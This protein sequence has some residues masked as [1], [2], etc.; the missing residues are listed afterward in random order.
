VPLCGKRAEFLP[1]ADIVR[2]A[3]E[4][5]SN[6]EVGTVDWVTFV[7]S[8]ETLLHLGLGRMLR[9]VKAITELPV[10][11]ITNG[12]LLWD[13]EVREELMPADAVLPS[14]DAGTPKLFRRINRPHPGLSFHQHLSGL[15]VFNKEYQGQLLL[16]VVL[17]RGVNDTETALS[18]LAAAVERIDPHG[19]HLSRPDRP[20]AE[21]WVTSPDEGGYMSAVAVLG[22]ATQVLHPAER[23]LVLE[24]PDG[25]L[26]TLLAVLTRHPLSEAQLKRALA[27]WS[28]ADVSRFL[29][30]LEGSP[31]VKKTTR[32]GVG[33]WVSSGAAFP[34]APSDHS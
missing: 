24:S 21:P 2:Q 6:L 33:F 15:E 26:E 19:I 31:A 34:E 25:A 1:T 27:Q 16:E 4:A 3:E 13:P 12:S 9:P 18:A 7:G 5:L 20:P 14:L 23:V 10:A 17:I 32:H 30:A 29:K 11:V 8:G 22:A 28:P